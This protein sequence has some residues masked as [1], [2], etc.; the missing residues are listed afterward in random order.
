VSTAARVSHLIDNSAL[1]TAAHSLDLC[2][3]CGFCL[4]AC[5]TYLAL[6]DENDSP[7]GRLL[8]MRSVV[9]GDLSIN[10]PT[11]QK[12]ID[13][14]LG[15][16][17]CESACPSGVPY[18]HLLEATRATIATTR[19]IPLL[20]RVT[21]TVMAS[22]VL[23]GMLFFFARLLRGSGIARWLSRVPGK[24]GLAF[25]M[26]ES[27]RCP[28][29]QRGYNAVG[30]GT[31]GRVATLTGCVMAGL[32]EATNHATERTLV[33]NDYQIARAPGQGC[34]GAL[35]AHAGDIER[36]RALARRNIEAFEESGADAIAVNAAGCA[37]MMRDYGQLLERDATWRARAVTVAAKT[38]DITELLA[39]SGPRTGSAIPCVVAYDAPCHLVHAQRVTRPPLVILQAIPGL[40]VSALPDADQCCGGA[41]IYNLLE[42]SLSREILTPKLATIARTG[43]TLIAT[44]NPGCIMQIGAGL[45]HAGSRVRCVHPVD[46]LDASYAE[47]R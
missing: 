22:R 21:L 3:H 29:P 34:C 31:R 1:A 6:S 2:V 35:H 7:R 5:P 15:C 13:R 43:A 23:R 20:A 10:D 17:A 25:A 8:L 30:N 41:G 37:A 12:H 45:L 16:R 36:A 32:F 39:A 27:T 11:L 33:V 47:A 38:R 46:L 4:Q 40:V 18:G 19:P 24:P 14:C 42:S 44:G 26:L 28:L 9:E